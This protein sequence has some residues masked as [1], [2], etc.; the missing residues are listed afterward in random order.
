MIGLCVY[1]YMSFTLCIQHPCFTLMWRGRRPQGT[2]LHTRVRSGVRPSTR[3]TIALW[4][5]CLLIVRE[6]V[7]G[8]FEVVSNAN[9]MGML[10]I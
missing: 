7:V 5:E 6:I 8:I 4:Y 3:D 1:W 9:S 10:V 2:I